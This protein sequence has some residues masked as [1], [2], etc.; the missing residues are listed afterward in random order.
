MTSR[1][2][3]PRFFFADQAENKR[4]HLCFAKTYVYYGTYTDNFKSYTC[5]T[6]VT[7]TDVVTGKLLFTG[8]YTTYPL[9]AK[10][11]GSDYYA[12]FGI[13]EMSA[14]AN[15]VTPLLNDLFGIQN[16]QQ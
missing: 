8:S 7:I 15:D 2:S 12:P 11:S 3:S 6:T 5:T 4:Y 10:W 1:P 16:T 13:D 9:S 14:F